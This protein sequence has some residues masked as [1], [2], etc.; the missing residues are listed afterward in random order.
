MIY[1]KVIY[2]SCSNYGF[3]RSFYV[4]ISWLGLDLV[5][6]PWKQT[7]ELSNSTSNLLL[8][9]MF[10]KQGMWRSDYF[11]AWFALSNYLSK[12]HYHNHFGGSILAYDQV[13]L[14]PSSSITCDQTLCHKIMTHLTIA[15]RKLLGWKIHCPE[16]SA[17]V[18]SGNGPFQKLEKCRKI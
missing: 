3:R 9:L 10:L 4:N 7:I 14:G 17:G 11:L 13:M 8:Q 6:I 2:D 18:L 1:K 12:W 5:R 16:P 15:H